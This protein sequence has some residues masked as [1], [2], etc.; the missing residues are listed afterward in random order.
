MSALTQSQLLTIN[1]TFGPTEALA[2]NGTPTMIAQCISS[3]DVHGKII[4]NNRASF[5]VFWCLTTSTTVTPTLTTANGI[6]LPAASYV[7]LDEVGGMALWQISGTT[8]SAGSGTR[9]T[10]GYRV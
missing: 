8:Q 4:L 10:G 3:V 1:V 7:T 5:S 6:E 9:V 2:L